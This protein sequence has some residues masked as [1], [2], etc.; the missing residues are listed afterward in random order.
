[1]SN[2]Q[3][4]DN[5]DVVPSEGE[6]ATEVEAEVEQTPEQAVEQ[7]VEQAPVPAPVAKVKSPDKLSRREAA[8]LS[9][10]VILEETDPPSSLRTTIIG[11]SLFIFAFLVWASFAQFDEKAIAPGEILPK[12]LVQ[13]VQHLEGG[14]IA[15]VL[16]EEGLHG[17]YKG[18]H[19]IAGV[20]G[21]TLES[22]R[23]VARNH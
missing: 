3:K 16:V 5:Q 17:R 10:A 22:R 23:P 18:S 4:D 19:L 9:R 15:A 6:D 7:A 12:S 13:P 21:K 20:V 14:I 11:V 2:D 1:M 8:M